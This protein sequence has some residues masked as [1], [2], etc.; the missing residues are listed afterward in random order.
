M[1]QEINEVEKKRDVELEIR[2][3]IEIIKQIQAAESS[4]RK[5]EPAKFV[6]APRVR[7][8]WLGTLN[9]KRHKDRLAARRKAAN[10]R[11]RQTRKAQRRAM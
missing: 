8:P 4:G 2:Q 9:W 3:N 10:K 7:H 1:R 5:K 11:A 6:P